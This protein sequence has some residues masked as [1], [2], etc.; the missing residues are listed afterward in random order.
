MGTVNTSP[1]KDKPDVLFSVTPRIEKVSN[2]CF[3]CNKRLTGQFV[4]DDGRLQCD[5]KSRTADARK[6]GN[7]HGGCAPKVCGNDQQTP[8][9][10]PGGFR[11]HLS[12]RSLPVRSTHEYDYVIRL[13]FQLCVE[14]QYTVG[15][16]LLK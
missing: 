15:R 14:E 2:S 7:F 11:A 6:L 3:E 10:R 1:N 12:Q 4:I 9:R 8:G 13:T 16:K 5:E